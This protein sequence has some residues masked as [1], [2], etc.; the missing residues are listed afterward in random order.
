MVK[1]RE[2]LSECFVTAAHGKYCFQKKETV[3]SLIRK[4]RT[5][6]GN[7]GQRRMEGSRGR[8]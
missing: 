5:A 3:S 8:L 6:L 1:E 4:I 2:G 7:V